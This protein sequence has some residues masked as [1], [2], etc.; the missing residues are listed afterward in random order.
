ML[1]RFMR[2]LEGRALFLPNRPAAEDL[3]NDQ[4]APE[5]YIARTPAG[6]I[7]AL[8]E[9]SDTGTGGVSLHDDAPG[10]ADCD[11]YCISDLSDP[12]LMAK[13]EGLSKRVYN[14]STVDVD[15]FRW[16]QIHRD[17]FGRWLIATGGGVQ[18]VT[19]IGG[20]LIVTRS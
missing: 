20:S 10:Y 11:I 9:G 4:Q 17:K 5:V 18:D 12:P 6:G 3:D 1:R 7:P 14:L 19:C 13:V 16:I 8:S 15:E 2:E